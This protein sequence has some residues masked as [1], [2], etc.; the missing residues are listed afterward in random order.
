MDVY[1][2]T[3]YNEIFNIRFTY[4]S[5]YTDQDVSYLKDSSSLSNQPVTSFGSPT[6]NSL[7]QDSNLE[8]SALLP[9]HQNINN[10]SGSSF[11]T[12]RESEFEKSQILVQPMD[13]V[14]V[15]YLQHFIISTI[16]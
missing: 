16:L 2:I 11:L 8:T 10:L 14:K 1:N 15:G 4:D 13:K 3:L 9:D 12:D 5:S 7:S 6:V